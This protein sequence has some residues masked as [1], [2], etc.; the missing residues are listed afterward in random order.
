MK[1]KIVPT[2]IV[3]ATL[4]GGSWLFWKELA[5]KPSHEGEAVAA[6]PERERTHIILPEEKLAVAG[7]HAT[8]VE[9]RPIRNI[10]TVPGR[11]QY[12]DSRHIEVKLPTEGILSD[13]RI[14]PGDVVEAGHV[15][16]ILS[17]PEVGN[18]R[19]D[20]LKLRAGLA[21]AQ[22]QLKWQDAICQG[23]KQLV[24]AV[25][26]DRDASAIL[27]DMNTASL[28]VYREQVM[29]AYTRYQLALSMASNANTLSESGAVSTSTLQQRRSELS[30]AEAALK[31]IVEQSQFDSQRKCAEALVDADDAKRRLK[32][33]EQH[34]Q[35]LLGYAESVEDDA[36]MQQL[37]HVEIRAPF[38]GTIED[39]HFSS[40]ER[41]AVGDSLC[42]LADTS[43]LW[44]AADIREREWGALRLQSGENIKV[45]TPGLPDQAL[46]AT[47]YYIGRQVDP[48]T[49][50]VP[51]VA[52]IDNASGLLRPGQFVRVALPVAAAREVTA[53][54]DSALLEHDQTSFVFIE[55]KPGEF[56]Q[57]L[58][59]RGLSD[60][61]WTEVTGLDPGTKVVSQG[62]FYLKSE[63]LLESEE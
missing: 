38:A 48:E 56:R 3:L 4:G 43:R 32:I 30:T 37:S 2:L 17:S 5:P 54:P 35:T 46:T 53:V 49:N 14:K 7:L 15:L 21:L 24:D 9:L 6:G 41:V 61:G 44:V 52:N 29:T 57:Q 58:V 12:D 63:L 13:V 50:A 36:D 11:I 39:R 42:V 51:I 47:V 26:A 31:A 19:A 28:G 18:A 10:Q 62:A 27:A 25:Q 8:P 20:V 34:L 45:T 40:Q 23:L 59:K 60:S 33:G 22:R 16:A 1:S 55:E